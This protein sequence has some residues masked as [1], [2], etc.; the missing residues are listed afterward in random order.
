MVNATVEFEM[1]I[2]ESFPSDDVEYTM[3]L[4]VAVDW[5]A[6]EYHTTDPTGYRF[7]PEFGNVEDR[8]SVLFHF[9]MMIQEIISALPF[10]ARYDREGASFEIEIPDMLDGNDVPT[11]AQVDTIKRVFSEARQNYASRLQ[12]VAAMASYL[13]AD[14]P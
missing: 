13:D 10:I 3:I 12:V 9:E 2:N 1:D 8:M 11:S 7:P 14:G 4:C 5:E 6:L